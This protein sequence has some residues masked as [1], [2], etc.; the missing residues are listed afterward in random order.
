MID[1]FG[2]YKPYYYNRKHFD[3][4]LDS[5]IS[6]LSGNALSLDW[7]D[8]SDESVAS[9]ALETWDITDRLA[10]LDANGDVATWVNATI[11]S[12]LSKDGDTT[13]WDFEDSAGNSDGTI[14]FVNGI[15]T[16]RHY[17]DESSTWADTTK[18]IAVADITIA[19]QTLS[20]SDKLSV[21]HA[22]A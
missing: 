22:A 14:T 11:A 5:V 19:G 18:S 8:D 15:A 12:I 20:T 9:D 4:V 16:V 3:G 13:G 10:I 7:L 21:V 1:K 2:R 6:A 17:A